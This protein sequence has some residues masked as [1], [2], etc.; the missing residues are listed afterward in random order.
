M[1][2]EPPTRKFV[3]GMF[4]G[5]SASTKLVGCAAPAGVH[6]SVIFKSMIQFAQFRAGLLGNRQ[7]TG[8]RGAA[9]QFLRRDDMPV[10]P[11]A[12]PLDAPHFLG[13]GPSRFLMNAQ[14]HVVAM[15]AIGLFT[16]AVVVRAPV[17]ITCFTRLFF[18]S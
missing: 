15:V 10:E 2:R 1:L 14:H 9:F 16:P 18:L 13:A 7:M 4:A 8:L 3:I 12:K 17:N 11:V 5:E 6:V